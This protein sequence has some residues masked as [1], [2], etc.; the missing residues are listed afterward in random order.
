V[1][2]GEERCSTDEL[3]LGSNVRR[4][5][6]HLS[7]PIQ[8]PDSACEGDTRKLR[9]ESLRNLITL[10]D[11]KRASVGVFGAGYVGLPLACAFA[12]AGFTTIAG[13]TDEEKLLAIG[14]GHAYVEDDYTRDILPRLVTSGKLNAEHDLSH[15][16]SIVDFAVIA[17][18]TPLNDAKE[19][20]LT[21]VVKVAEVIAG[22][23]RPGKFI[24]L[25]SSVYPGAT[26]DVV[27]PILER[28]GLKAG[29]D[30]GLACSP[31]RIDFGSHVGYNIKRIPK[32]VGGI[33]P[34][35][36]S[37]ATQLYASVLQAKI[38]PVSNMRV[39]E[40]TKMLENTY[41]Y[42]NI[43]L[44][45]ELAILHEKLGIDFFEVIAAAST[46]PFGFQAFYPGPGVGGRCIPKDPRYLL[47]RAHQ[48][49]ESLNV[50]EASNGVND[51][52][53]GYILERLENRLKASG[54]HIRGSKAVI[55]GLAFKADVLDTRNSPSIA[56]AE[57]LQELGATV[58]AYDPF[59]KT[60]STKNG[61]LQSASTLESAASNTSIIVLMTSHTVFKE[62]NLQR[63]NAQ[64]HSLATIVD[65]RGYW[66]P[67]ECRSAGFDYIGLGRPD[68]C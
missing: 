14:R 62:I 30:F 7:K 15:L 39:A 42:V 36:T 64:A 1:F 60:V 33:T 68:T 47:Y 53:I 9:E 63:L 44:V 67:Q 59:V 56:M 46:K 8:K 49:G 3:H 34:L 55:L 35:C 11:S 23:M 31:E 65:T 41:R 12:E 13:D 5:G 21:Y 25:E 20:D 66:S 45:N 50:V 51:R 61:P 40:A 17:V 27:R 26:D 2:R 24:I 43:A 19:P 37:I 22:Q 48:V 38:V 52:M 29:D 16:A 4:I 54:K 58:S 57:R 6:R 32:V 28:S 10:L 18:P